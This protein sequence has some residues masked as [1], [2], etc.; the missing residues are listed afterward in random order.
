MKIYI[1]GQGE[2]DIDEALKIVTDEWIARGEGSDQTFIDLKNALIDARKTRKEI[3]ETLELL[4]S[5]E[6]RIRV[7]EGDLR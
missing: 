5:H 6:Q 1:P 2:L 7:L 4:R 3:S